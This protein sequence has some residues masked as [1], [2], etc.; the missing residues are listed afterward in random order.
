MP[1][2]D[3]GRYRIRDFLAE[4]IPALTELRNRIYPDNPSSVEEVRHW[5]RL[6]EDPHLQYRRWAVE[7]RGSGRLAAM[8][9]IEQVPFNYHPRKFWV[10]VLV[11]PDHRR[12]G[13]GTTLYERLEGEARSRDAILLW[14]GVRADLPDSV[15]FFERRGFLELRRLRRS[16]LDLGAAPP[17][18]VA[19]PGP[20]RAEGLQFTTLE[21]EGPSRDEVR[22]KLYGLYVRSSEG[23]PTMGERTPLTFEQFVQFELEGPDFFPQGTFLAVDGDR[24]VGLT[25]IEPQPARPD[26]A[27]VAFTG[28]VPEYRGRGVATELKRRSV[29]FARR[30]GFRWMDT[31]NDYA[32]APIWSIN[33]RLGFRTV[34]T[35]ITGEKTLT[36]PT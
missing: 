26:T 5:M 34:E 7:E 30:A 3:E 1:G 13:L 10:D 35:F 11:D 6:L 33:E 29:E 4:D 23:I 32:N 22:R 17:P 28:T 36:A 25:V 15:R 14:A 9:G 19:P 12:R 2:F 16:R 31:G 18:G 20:L 27:H 24:Y 8:G 21:Q